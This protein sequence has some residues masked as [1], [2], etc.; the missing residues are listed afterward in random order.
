MNSPTKAVMVTF[1]Y[2]QRGK[3]GT[4]LAAASLLAA[5]KHHK[6][7]KSEFS[8]E[9]LA[10]QMPN[11]NM[12]LLTTGDVF[13]Q[14]ESKY[15]VKNID[16][17]IL[18][19]YVWSTHLIEPLIN[20]CK[21]NGFQGKTIL[22]GYQIVEETCMQLYPSAD[23]YISSYAELALPLAILHKEENTILSTGKIINKNMDKDEDFQN[24]PSPYLD[25]TYP[26]YQ[27]QKMIHWETHR[28]CIFKCNFCLHRDI[29][30][31]QVFDLDQGRIM[32]ELRLFE[33]MKIQKI[34][35]LDPVFNRGPH[36]KAV[37]KE[38][39]RIK[40]ESQL[41]LQVRFELI[42]EEFLSLCSQLNVH[43]EF[44]LQTAIKEEYVTIE[45]PNNLKKVSTA[46]KMLNEYNQSFE[47][48]LIYGLPNQTLDSFIESIDFLTDEGI[49]NIK[50]FPLM[51]LEGTELKEKKAEFGLK[52]GRIDN[53]GIP[54]VIES[55]T[56][57][58]KDWLSMHHIATNL[59]KQQKQGDA[60]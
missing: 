27:N 5:C 43:M 58:H 32:H 54:H 57:S 29:K 28:G 41:C 40:L 31:N 20:L 2:S 12:P 56:F 46:I 16:R 10:I 23:Y 1:D 55:N 52:E 11:E 6:S 8:I 48:S 7:Y 36:H 38:A 24:L 44:G 53:S 49:T 15:G 59:S 14:L 51:L 37:L 9:H 4:G 13:Q 60:E 26:L 33:R 50:A 19:C 42:D 47:V 35:V 17:L 45:R 30:T 3:S 18:A 25:G 21:K 34:N 22:G 39:I